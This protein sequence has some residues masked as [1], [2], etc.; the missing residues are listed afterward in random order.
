MKV[1]FKPTSEQKQAAHP[2]VSVWASANAGSGKTHVLVDRLVRLLLAGAE[3]ST[4]LCITFTKAAAAE[5]SNRLFARLGNWA[6]KSDAELQADLT[7]LGVEVKG[8]ASLRRAR[9][10]FTLALESPGGMKVQTIHGFCQSLLQLFPVEAGLAPGFSV[11]DEGEA[12]S[13]RQVAWERV[14][15]SMAH[16]PASELAVAFARL[17]PAF[18]GERFESAL[19]V[20]LKCQAVSSLAHDWGTMELQALAARSLGVDPNVMQMDVLAEA[21]TISAAGLQD[22]IATFR[23]AAAYGQQKFH[24]ASAL[25]TI[26]N[27]TD[28]ARR[29]ELIRAN[30]FTG[31]GTRI[32]SLMLSS[33]RDRH[34]DAHESLLGLVDEMSRLLELLDAQTRIVLTADLLLIAK[35]VARNYETEKRKL[36]VHDFADL[37][38]R[39]AT[40]LSQNHAAQWVLYKLDRGIEHVLVDEAQDTNP[41]Q[42]SIVLALTEEFFAGEGRPGNLGRTLFVVGDRKQSIYSF[43]GADAALFETV[44]QSFRNRVENSKHSYRDVKLQVSYRSVQDVLNVVDAVFPARALV[45]MGFAD[46]GGDEAHSSYR[47]NEPGTFELW[48][49]VEPIDSEEPVAWDAPVDRTNDDAPRK[50]LARHIAD[51][52]KSW[53]G[54]RL[55]RSQNRAVQADDILI[56]V[57]RRGV[58]FSMLIAELRRAGIAVAGADRLE[59]QASLA[60]KDL[61]ALAQF[62]LLPSD[63]YSLACVL[64]SPLVDHALSDDV[65][66][67]LASG[68]TETLWDRLQSSTDPLLL[69]NAQGLRQLMRLAARESPYHF[70]AAVMTARRTAVATRLGTESLDATAAFLDLLLAHGDREASSLAGFVTWFLDDDITIRRDMDKASGEVRIMTV[71]GAK[72]L[73]ANIV[74]MPDATEVKSADASGLVVAGSGLP[75]VTAS[76]LSRL[77]QIDDLKQRRDLLQAQESLR[78]LYV[79]MTRARDELYVCGSKSKNKVPENSWYSLIATLLPTS[80]L[81]PQLRQ[82]ASATAPKQSVLRYGADPVEMEAVRT[83]DVAAIAIPAWARAESRHSQFDEDAAGPLVVTDADGM[84]LSDSGVV[85]GI[86]MHRLLHE[87]PD[88][89]KS[90]RL[91][92]GLRFGGQ[93][94]L[95]EE[96]VMSAI[97]V[98]DQ[99]DLAPF[100]TPTSSGEVTLA[101]RFEDGDLHR[102]RLDRLAINDDGLY[103]LDYKT[104][105][106]RDAALSGGHPYVQ[107]IA[108]YREGLKEAYPGLA[109]KAAILWTDSGKLNWVSEVSQ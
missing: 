52:I 47:A 69:A 31:S 67:T 13:L 100:F 39:T 51:T 2:G 7:L 109:I 101:V 16:E 36:G 40:M 30:F 86:A 25:R 34:W 90:E 108:R 89:T 66:F 24:V 49:V 54:K 61:L 94:G 55:L 72:G 12:R 48:P 88:W 23:D 9:Q 35:T 68:R 42:W 27:E 1:S 65:L 11:L 70:F 37:I 73:E 84:A 46:T 21:M 29:L 19:D 14:Q 79:A 4:I 58:L 95:S 10:L 41:Q 106:G 64:K 71:H 75:I 85:R 78:L 99:N 33:V 8:D 74:I 105:T 17:E 6:I 28:P 96:D 26:A 62:V 43:Q 44:R 38:S 83:P 91:Q 107:Q 5:M 56:L 50:R 81:A 57:Q 45:N 104:G 92:S 18:S 32:K 76:H 97:K 102:I 59:L 82:A 15:S 77:P 20:A 53:N 63:D 80:D 3:P 93:L 98:L 87:L 103:L 60:I 22:L